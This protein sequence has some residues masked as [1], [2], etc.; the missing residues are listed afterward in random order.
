MDLQKLLEQA[1]KANASDIHLLAGIPPSLRIDGSLQSAPGYDSMQPH[2]IESM[3]FSILTPEQKEILVTNKELDF[4]FGYGGGVYGDQGRFRINAYYQ[5]NYL[6][7]ALRYLPPKIRSVDELG[8]PKVCHDFALLKQGFVLVTGPTGHGK[9]TTLAAI[10]NEINLTRATHI[11]T[12]EDPIEYVYPT[13][14]SIISQRE[15][16]GDTHS[17]AMALKSALREDPD[18][19]LVGE[20]R[21]PETMQAAITLAET[22]HLVFAT[23]HTNSAAQSIDRIVDAFPADQREQVRIQLAATLRGIVSQRLLPKIGGGRVAAD[24]ILIGTP[25]VAS[26]IR[27]GKTHL[28]DSV[29]QTSKDIGMTTLEASLAKL[30][31]AGVISLDEAKGYALREQELLRMVQG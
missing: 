9:S 8:L 22:G 1:V 17:W 24:E 28:I 10:L 23:L 7:A 3:I 18:V 27:D 2:D 4:S 6:G 15:I 5:R 16:G 19:V 13:G 25:A 30:V 20:M 31:L 11:L 21:D 12:I 26:N 14:K 29:I